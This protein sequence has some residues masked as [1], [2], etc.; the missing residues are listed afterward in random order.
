ME[1]KCARQEHKEEYSCEV[2]PITA[3]HE[4]VKSVLKW[5]EKRR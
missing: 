3:A 1:L 5:W 2:V 4:S